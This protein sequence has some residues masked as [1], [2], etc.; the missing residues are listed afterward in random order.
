MIDAVAASAG[1]RPAGLLNGVTPITATAAGTATEKM[2]AD[3]KLLLGALT[4]A[5][6]DGS[7]IVVL[8][9]PAQALSMNFAMTTTGDFLFGGTE[10]AGQRFGVS[11]IPSATVAAGRVI[12]IDA[13]E[14]A[15][16]TGDTPRFAVS[17][18]ATLHEE[19][20]TPLAIGTT[21]SPATVAAPA[22]SLFQTDSIAIRLSLHVSW[23]M[24]RTGMVQTIASV[25][26]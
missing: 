13:D 5:G 17:N 19:D 3:F 14:F 18:E 16:A 22:R 25:G 6:S 21:G 4:A 23:A 11:I 2:I 20:T 24:R 26:W 7:N 1:V 8:V 12:A 9:N 10:G 15:T